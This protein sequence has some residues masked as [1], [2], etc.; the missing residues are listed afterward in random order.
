ML[1]SAARA[2]P[3]AAASSGGAPASRAARYAP[4]K[5]S[6]AA[7]VSTTVT[8]GTAGTRIPPGP[9]AI[10][11]PSAPSFTAISATP[12]RW[13][14]RTQAFASGSPNTC[15]SSARVG[16][17]ISTC[18]SM[19][20]IASR[21]AASEGQPLAR[22]FPSNATSAPRF[23]AAPSTVVNRA[24]AAGVR[25]DS[26]IAEKYT[27]SWSATASSIQVGWPGPNS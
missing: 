19:P 6:P 16:S 21:A 27:R 25:I 11:Q 26:V 5:A 12:A 3:A 9:S 14:R 10:R 18:G 1:P 13:S 15:C 22:K 8:S 2:F 17:T 20:V 24:R 23:L 7:V 4:L